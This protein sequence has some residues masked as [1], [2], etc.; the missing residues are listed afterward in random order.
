VESVRLDVNETEVVVDHLP[1]GGLAHVPR[2]K[3]E[4]PT[5]E[6]QRAILAYFE[7]RSV[8]APRG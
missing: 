6:E 3:G 8:G 2:S 4:L 5:S 1:V 7:I